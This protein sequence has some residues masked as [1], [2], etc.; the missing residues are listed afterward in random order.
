M[1]LANIGIELNKECIWYNKNRNLTDYYGNTV[2]DLL[3]KYEREWKRMK[4]N[5]INNF[6]YIF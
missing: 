6:K 3:R 2:Y 5:E 4:E 1:R